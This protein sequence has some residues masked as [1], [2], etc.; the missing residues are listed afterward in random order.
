MGCHGP[1]GLTLALILLLPVSAMSD[2]GVGT[3]DSA[4]TPRPQSL[5][6][7]FQN[8][9]LSTM[10]AIRLGETTIA[11]L[12]PGAETSVNTKER[13]PARGRFSVASWHR[14]KGLV[15]PW[16]DF[17]MRTAGHFL[18]AVSPGSEGDPDSAANLRA[19]RELSV[20]ELKDWSKQPVN[21]QVL[22][23]RASRHTTPEFVAQLMISVPPDSQFEA[24]TPSLLPLGTPVVNIRRAIEDMGPAEPILQALK[25]QPKWAEDRGLSD[26]RLLIALGLNA[27]TVLKPAG[28]EPTL[29]ALKAALSQGAQD[30]ALAEAIG[31]ANMQSIDPV[32]GLEVLRLGCVI[33][34]T[35]AAE[36]RRRAR[37]LATEAYLRLAIRLCGDKSTLRDRIGHY[38]RARAEE[39]QA[40]LNLTAAADWLTAAYWIGQ[41]RRDKAF[42]ADTLAELAIIQFRVEDPYRGR[43]YLKRAQD[44]DPH[45]PRVLKAAEYNPQT[46]PRARV[47]V[48]II[49]FFLAIFAWRRVKRAMFG[50]LG[51]R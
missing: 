4:H 31:F 29:T 34:D 17:H 1:A 19:L 8:N 15:E 35:A 32:S 30:R 49:I 20:L 43:L 41:D 27:P 22:L 38:Y 26:E 45:R 47:A 9:S 10:V 11:R 50:D 18:D 7:T 37:W 44:L 16:L 40:R 46:D 23:T 13:L 6:Q 42:L 14:S 2:G 25:T 36:S 21:W 48:S 39:A 24:P 5:S 12:E 51:R 28:Q 3:G 33:L